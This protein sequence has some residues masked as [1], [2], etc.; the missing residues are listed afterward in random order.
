MTEQWTAYHSRVR[1]LP[2]LT[3]HDNGIT[4]QVTYSLLIGTDGHVERIKVATHG[5]F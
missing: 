3:T 2:I 1:Y 5:R 4:G